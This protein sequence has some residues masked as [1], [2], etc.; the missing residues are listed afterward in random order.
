[1]VP[2]IES[3]RIDLDKLC[4]HRSVRRL[5]LFGSATRE[6]FTPASD[7]DFLVEFSG[8]PS[9]SDYLGLREDLKFLFGREIDL[10]MPTAVRNPYIRAAIERDRQL[11]YAA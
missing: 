9:L 11:L 5:E 8:S 10:V 6:D 4:R 1:V 7:L 3:R 2:I